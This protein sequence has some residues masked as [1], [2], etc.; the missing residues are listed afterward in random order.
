MSQGRSWSGTTSQSKTPRNHFEYWLTK[1]EL[2]IC[3]RAQPQPEIFEHGYDL[4]VTPWRGHQGQLLLHRGL[5]HVRERSR[6]GRNVALGGLEEE[7]CCAF[8]DVEDA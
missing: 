7:R 5:Q 1:L 6:Q 2:V 3:R 4:K 8:G